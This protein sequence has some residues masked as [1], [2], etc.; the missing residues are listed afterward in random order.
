MTKT[1]TLS[2]LGSKLA[3][4]LYSSF[5]EHGPAAI[6]KVRLERPADYLRIIASLMPKQVEI[7]TDPFDGVSDHELAAIVALAQSQVAGTA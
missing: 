6:K 1:A 5:V 3:D 2:H 4:D 7:Q